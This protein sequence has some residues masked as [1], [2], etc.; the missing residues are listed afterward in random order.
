MGIIIKTNKPIT[1]LKQI[2]NDVEEESLK[3]WSLN[4]DGDFFHNR[5][6]WVGKGWL[7]ALIDE[8]FLRFG[9]VENSSDFK[10]DYFAHIQGRFTGMLI[11]NYSKYF[12]YVSTTSKPQKDI[13]TFDN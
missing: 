10:K 7:R 9:F 6:Q 11:N 1:L 2:K 12:E 5:D 13:D 8:G 3:T 4:K